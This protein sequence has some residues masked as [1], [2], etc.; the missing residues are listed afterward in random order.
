MALQNPTA[1][2][3]KL[4]LTTIGCFF[5]LSSC[6]NQE[7]GN[8]NSETRSESLTESGNNK[9]YSKTE[10]TSKTD[11]KDSTGTIEGQYIR[12]G[13]EADLNCECYCLDLNFTSTSELCLSP[14]KIYINGKFEKTNNNLINVYLTDPSD[15]NSE[16]DKIPWAKFDRNIPIAT[17]TPQPNG[18][19][20]LDW[21]GFSING[22]LAM[23]YA[24]F[25]KKTLEGKFK[26]K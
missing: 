5:I 15:I 10:S 24:I 1:M 18:E 23:D 2:K 11:S 20:D 7:S 13:E 22:D 19:L 26:K 4:I 16:G 3:F 25:G 9:D 12:I 14:D 8:H 6:K 17:I 21:L